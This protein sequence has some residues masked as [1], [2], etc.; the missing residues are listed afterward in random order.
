LAVFLL[1]KSL[2]LLKLF[3]L[4]WPPKAD[5]LSRARA[6]VIRKNDI[7]WGDFPS[8]RDMIIAQMF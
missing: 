1:L 8:G 7:A 3:T 5:T 4:T 6:R 2:C